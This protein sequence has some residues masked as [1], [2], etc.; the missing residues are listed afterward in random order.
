M[1]TVHLRINVAA[2][3]RP[4]PVRLR[5]TGPD[6]TGFAPFGRSTEFPCGRGEQVGGHLKLG[7]DRWVYTDGSCE[8]ALPA[9]V[10]LRVQVKKG[11]EYRPLDQTVT[12]GPGQLTLRLAVERWSG[13]RACR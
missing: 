13:P 2:T 9:G 1:L 3:G 6:G 10:P 8:A 5:I 7:Q 11:P 4:T 12:L